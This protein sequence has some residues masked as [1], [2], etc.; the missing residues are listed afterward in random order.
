MKRKRNTKLILTIILISKF[1]LFFYY[2]SYYS[3]HNKKIPNPPTV[4]RIAKIIENKRISVSI[5]LTYLTI[6]PNVYAQLAKLERSNRPFSLSPGD[7]FY[8]S[9]LPSPLPPP[10]PSL[11]ES[12][13][14][15][16]AWDCS[17]FVYPDSFRA[18]RVTAF[19]IHINFAH[20]VICMRNLAA[21]PVPRS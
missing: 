2:F 8:L 3:I 15:A 1:S 12:T 21:P 7:K 19:N 14:S 4:H 11:H 13:N 18:I 9:T 20:G 17:N 5:N 6:L 10:P 16:G